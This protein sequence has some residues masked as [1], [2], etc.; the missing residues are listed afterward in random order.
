MIAFSTSLTKNHITVDHFY[1]GSKNYNQCILSHTRDYLTAFRDKKTM[2]R[3]FMKFNSEEKSLIALGL[4]IT[5]IYLIMGMLIPQYDWDIADW[6]SMHSL[7][8]DIGFFSPII[9]HSLLPGIFVG[10]FAN[11]TRIAL[12]TSHIIVSCV[13]TGLGLIFLMIVSY[14][15]TGKI[16]VPIIMAVLLSVSRTFL[17]ISLSGEN[18]L[19]GTFYLV[20]LLYFTW[21]VLTKADLPS[22]DRKVYYFLIGLFSAGLTLFH[23]QM[24]VIGVI[25]PGI[26]VITKD[27]VPLWKLHKN[28]ETVLSGIIAYNGFAIGI[29]VSFALVSPIMGYSYSTFDL[30]I[31]FLNL[32]LSTTEQFTSNPSWFFLASG[33]S[34][35]EQLDIFLSGMVRA[36]YYNQFT[37]GNNFFYTSEFPFIAL[38]CIFCINPVVDYLFRKEGDNK[39]KFLRVL[40]AC[41]AFYAFYMFL[42]EPNSLERWSPFVVLIGF[43]NAII[44]DFPV[45]NNIDFGGVS[46]KR[47][48]LVFVFFVGLF[49]GF[50]IDQIV[51]RGGALDPTSVEIL[52]LLLNMIVVSIVGFLILIPEKIAHSFSNFRLTVIT[53]FF[54]LVIAGIFIYLYFVSV[55]LYLITCGASQAGWC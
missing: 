4:V 19:V 55:F 21:V 6:M 10:L 36:F 9:P 49:I 25:I 44:L 2:S 38:S 45:L 14:R 31:Q 7:P 35:G 52:F 11:F 12:L 27:E 15:I 43:H 30:L 18:D 16:I 8:L 22:S 46:G 32:N 29:I 53:T 26:L 50:I 1:H 54:L 20:L 47:K 34:L 48:S 33:R 17:I 51:I 24:T 39:K 42:Y 5:L 41:E 40:L 13:F 3:G 23:V 37:F 28:K